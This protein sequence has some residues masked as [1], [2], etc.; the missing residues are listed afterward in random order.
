[1]S[2]ALYVGTM[3]TRGLGSHQTEGDNERDKYAIA[4]TDNSN[5]KEN[6]VWQGRFQA[7]LPFHPPWRNNHWL[8]HRKGPKYPLRMQSTGSTKQHCY[9]AQRASLCRKGYT[10]D[11]TNKDTLQD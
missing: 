3:S 9:I 7:M 5:Y 4:I 2:L 8:D 11:E 6:K 10:Y 1:M